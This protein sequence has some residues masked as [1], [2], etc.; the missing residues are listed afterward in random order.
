[1][2]K[3]FRLIHMSDLHFG[4]EVAPVVDAVVDSISQLSPQLIVVTGD[5]TQRAR[6]DQFLA[7]RAFLDKLAPIPII[8][9]PGNH[10]IPLFDL[11]TRFVNPYRGY[12]RYFKGSLSGLY[13]QD[14]VEVLSLNST[15]CLRHVQGELSL[16]D[17][18]TGLSQFQEKLRIVAFHH[19][20]DCIQD[21]DIENLLKNRTEAMKL[22]S[23]YKVDLV[24]GGH[25][26]DPVTRT[27]LLRYPEVSKPFL[28]SVAG[29]TVSHRVRKKAPN[30]FN[31]YD[32]E[33]DGH[34]YMNFQR[35]EFAG[36]RFECET[37][38]TFTRSVQH[39][40]A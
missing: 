32:F 30:S 9:T 3:I 23:Q 19:P 8:S 10:D 2:K 34:L 25:I 18:E 36:N 21:I 22:F 35:Y 11:W 13:A 20:M 7:A 27:T 24:V 6:K 39:D 16:E 38:Q 1:M 15:H 40:W 37:Q 33:R 5:I 26:H 28:V 31:V 17:L 12:L 29:T 14:G 4:T